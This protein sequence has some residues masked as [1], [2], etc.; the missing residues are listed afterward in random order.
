LDLLWLITSDLAQQW[1][2][3]EVTSKDW[4]DLWLNEGLSAFLASQF[5]GQ[6]LGKESYE[7]QIEQS[8]QN[9]SVLRAEG[10]D[11]P[12]S[13]TDWTTRQDLDDAIPVQKGVCFLYALSD[14]VGDRAFSDGLRLYTNAHWGQ[15]VSS[16]D[17]QNA[18]RSVYS[19][20]KSKTRKPVKTRK[21]QGDPP[22]TPLDKLFDLWVYGVSSGNSK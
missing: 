8:W 11:R 1:Y 20:D 21:S 18:F 6:R 13:N 10:K 16:E 5:L 12:L 14:L 2:G 4:S 3:I 17:F 22:V 19:G 9:Y 7:R 15:T